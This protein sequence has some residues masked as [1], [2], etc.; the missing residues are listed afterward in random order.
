MAKQ[1][2]FLVKFIYAAVLIIPL[3]CAY[4]RP[5]VADLEDI[6]SDDTGIDI[7]VTADLLL[8][9]DTV[10]ARC[11]LLHQDGTRSPAD[12]GAA[13]S[14]GDPQVLDADP[15]SGLILAV[16]PGS[17]NIVA[18]AGGFSTTRRITVEGV[19]DYTGLV[20]SEVYY[21][22]K[23]KED[24]EFIEL[25]N[26]S[27]TEI[28]LSG[29]GLVDGSSSSKIFIITPGTVISAGGFLVIARKPDIFAQEFSN[30]PDL[31]GYSFSLN[32]DNEA[33][34]IKLNDG[35]VL[36]SVYLKGG[37]AAFPA[38]DGWCETKHPSSP[39][40]QS[41]YRISPDDSDTCADWSA[42]TPTP[43]H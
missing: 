43:G 12:A 19:P 37:T 7:V 2:G 11:Y 41:V 4:P 38:P 17:A 42:G 40:G 35:T 5:Y 34:F 14:T 16:G 30:P 29:L 13:W 8:V 10:Q 33:V 21:D 28:D 6:R 26:G 15:S 27:N 25:Y 9:N 32:N 31:W 22:P 36:D 20:I 23:D 3:A 39:E 1:Q 24:S 18:E